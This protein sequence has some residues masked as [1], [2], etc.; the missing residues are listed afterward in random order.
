MLLAHLTNFDLP[1]LCAAFAA[2]LTIGAAAMA[3]IQAMRQR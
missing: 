2:G 3:A 1:S